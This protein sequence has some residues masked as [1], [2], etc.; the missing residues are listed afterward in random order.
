MEEN[1][2]YVYINLA[3]QDHPVGCL[4]SYYDRGRESASFRYDE[5]WFANPHRFELEPYLGLM[6]GTFHTDGRKALFACF[7]D[8]AP[9]TW[10]RLLIRRREER[11]AIREKRAVRGFRALDYLLAVDDFSRHGAMRFKTKPDGEFVTTRSD[12]ERIPPLLA[13]PKLLAASERV[14]EAR[15]SYNDLKELLV[16][17]SSLGGARPKASVIDK[18]G[19]L[20]IAK[21]PKR[22][23]DNNNV[24][25][26]AVALSL[27]QE[28]GLYVEEWELCEVMGNKSV[29][30]LKRFDRC[31]KLRLPFISAMSMLNANDG[32]SGNYSYLDIAEVVLTRCG[33]IRKNLHELWCRILFSVLISNTDDHLRNHGF[34]MSGGGEWYLSPLYDVNPSADRFSNLQLNIDQN[35]NTASID[36]VLSVADYFD[37]SRRRAEEILRHQRGVVSEWKN[38]AR[39][40]GISRAEISRM[41]AAFQH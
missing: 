39:H 20:R 12:G 4:W 29:L 30:L 19:N 15:E 17:G 25:W 33:D 10:G 13:L 36:L 11:Q 22:N 37:L 31:G 34:L 16:P 6:E 18:E 5:S 21:F 1:T 35:D 38:V 24:L 7:S 8:S 3:G 23:D 9:D 32:E 27:A 14:L 41:S 40:F 2:T 28:A 26:E